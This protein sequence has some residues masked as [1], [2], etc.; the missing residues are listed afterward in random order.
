MGKCPYCKNELAEVY[1]I[2]DSGNF[3]KP[4]IFY[5]GVCRRYLFDLIKN[6]GK[7]DQYAKSI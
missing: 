1:D 6:Y 2:Y 3:V 4:G 5:C 7:Q